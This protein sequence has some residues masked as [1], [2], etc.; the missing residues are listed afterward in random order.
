MN[1]VTLRQAKHIAGKTVFVR[2]DFNVPI[3]KG[4]ITEDFKS[5]QSLPTIRFLMRYRCKI[6]LATHLGDPGGK[7]VKELSTAPIAKRLAK[8]LGKKVLFVPESS[9]PEAKKLI[10]EAPAGAL[11]LLENLRFNPGEEK[12]DLRFGKSLAELAE[13]YVNN[14]F[15][16]CHRAHASVAAIKKYLPACA[17]LLL[18]EEVRNLAKAFDPKKPLVVVLGGAKI[19]TKLPL[20]NNFIKRA[21]QILVGGAL[22][23]D[24]L[25]SL[26]YEVG[27]SLVSADAPMQKAAVKA[28]RQAGNHKIIL[29]VDAVVSVK[30]DG[31]GEV[32]VKKITEVSKRDFIYDIGPETVAVFSHY[33]KRAQTIVWN[34]P[35]GWFEQT[36]FKHATVALGRVIA[37][38]S[39]GPAFGL[40]GGGETVEALRL[41][42]MFDD[43]DWVST[44]GGAMLEFLSGT[45]LPGLAGIV[46]YK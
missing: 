14:A 16:V 29:P 38:R 26:G 34:G 32:R 40:V 23:N 17:G 8:L 6:V 9:G 44:G 12:N 45:K 42:K 10:A 31:G 35:M 24:F 1:I 4:K 5:A 30:K 21:D 27:R 7:V 18:E 28:Y 36:Q 41:T 25:K 33:L 39:S 15:A 46:V 13:V 11:I 43:I 19:S 20:I 37:S 2:V 22:A 3:K